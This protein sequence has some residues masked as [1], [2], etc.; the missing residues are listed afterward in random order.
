MGLHQ[1]SPIE[2]D[3]LYGTG[4]TTQAAHGRAMPTPSSGRDSRRGSKA[5]AA[6]TAGE[7]GYGSADRREKAKSGQYAAGARRASLKPE[8]LN[9]RGGATGLR[10][11][12]MSRGNSAPIIERS[13]GTG[14]ATGVQEQDEGE[15]ADNA[16]QTDA[17]AGAAASGQDED[18]VAG[19]VGAVKQYAPF[20]NPELEEPLPEINIAVTGGDG[21]GKSTLIQRALDLPFLAPSLAAE[22]KIPYE[23]TVYLIRLLEIPIDDVDI[24]DDDTISWPGTIADKMMPRIDGV[25]TLYDVKDRGSLEDVPETLAAIQKAAIPSVLVSCKCDTHPAERQVDPTG[26]ELKARQ[27][28]KTLQTLQASAGHPETYKRG[29]AMLVKS[30]VH[31]EAAQQARDASANRRRAQSNALRPISPRP[32]SLV[33]HA[34]ANSEHSMLSQYKD[35]LHSRHDS[36]LAGYSG[37]GDRLKVPHEQESELQN[38]FLFEESGTEASQ[39]PKS[40]IEVD[41]PTPP[42]IPAQPTAALAENGASFEDLVDRLLAQPTSKQ[43][44]KFVV[45]FLALYRKFAAPGRLLEAIA[46][47]FDTL[48]RNGTANMIKMVAQLR[49]LAIMEQWISHYPGDFAFQKT[50]RRMRT[51]IAKMSA[52]SIFN[53]AAKEMGAGLE[54]VQEDDDTNWA[55]GDKNREA[56]NSD[57][58]RWTMSSTAS[59]LIDDE[60]FIYPDNMSVTTTGDDASVAATHGADTVRSVSSSTTSSQLMQNVESAQRQAQLLQPRNRLVLSKMEWRMLME[61]PEDLIAKELTRQDWIMFSSI[62]PRDLVR[63]VSLKA[64]EQAQCK[65]LVN[66]NRMIDHFNHLAAWVQNFI[67]LRDKP[68]HRALMLEKM[69]KIARKVRELNNYNALGAFI[70]GIKST[71]VYRL[72]ATRNLIPPPVSKDW[73]KLEILMSHS[74]SYSAYRLA[75]ENSS[76]ERI[77]YIPL[78][79]RDLVSA[80]EGN[81][82]FIGEEKNAR[83]NWKKFEVMGEVIVGLQRAQGLPY[84]GLGT[85]RGG[86]QVRELVLDMKLVKD[87]DVSFPRSL[88]RHGA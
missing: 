26:I 53:V 71:A 24:D 10:R 25:L 83:I 36:S 54:A 85:G 52:V 4:I 59:T 43:D 21:V 72:E 6:Q 61:I 50:R 11:P 86:E 63:Q 87:E 30:V 65:N 60:S 14:Y 2:K 74:R 49:C 22:R 33:G 44:G 45:I 38:S 73:M 27:A 76:A 28:V 19:V 77:P 51:F 47:R 7:N 84:R 70:A 56:T 78:H 82:T 69:M 46:E 23:G 39:S 67:L 18:E 58:Y 31:G 42:I 88:Y 12:G 8:E 79:R 80:E 3:A 5:N 75:W 62:R 64:A 57:T 35:K 29:L 32:P 13:R 34:R 9:G 41:L 16:R 81:K 20:Q 1:T 66:V 17:G 15:Q 68:K 37:G 48:E 55:Y 40:S